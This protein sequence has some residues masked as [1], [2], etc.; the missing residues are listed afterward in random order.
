MMN[1]MMIANN[2]S[3]KATLNDIRVKYGKVFLTHVWQI[4]M[5]FHF[6]PSI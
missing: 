6:F 1:L 4:F 5:K 2:G 3:G